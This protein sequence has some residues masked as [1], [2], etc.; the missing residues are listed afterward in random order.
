MK[1][2]SAPQRLQELTASSG[3]QTVRSS[4]FGL[5]AAKFGVL[6]RATCTWLE[7]ASNDADDPQRLALL[8]ELVQVQILDWT[9]GERDEPD[10]GGEGGPLPAGAEGPGAGGLAEGEGP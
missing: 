4:S 3:C 1:P 6:R 7:L 10:G 9:Q 8:E 5:E 2:N